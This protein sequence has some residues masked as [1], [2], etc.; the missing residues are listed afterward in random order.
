MDQLASDQNSGLYCR[1][2]RERDFRHGLL[3]YPKIHTGWLSTHSTG[4]LRPFPACQPTRHGLSLLPYR[5]GKIIPLECTRN[6]DLH[7]LSHSDQIPQPEIGSRPRILENRE[8]RSLGQ[9]S[10]GPRLRLLQP[11]R[12]RKSGRQLCG[13]PWAGQPHGSRLPRQAPQHGLVPRVPSRPAKSPTSARP[14]HQLGLET[15]GRHHPA[16][17]GREVRPRLEC[18]SSRQLQ[19]VSP[20]IP[21]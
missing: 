10:Q 17:V 21:R 14:D 2:G 16:G 13:L 4:G 12:A 6:A 8:S 11:F 18:E 20:L 9:D 5:R 3:L 7:E 1:G 19:R 15:S